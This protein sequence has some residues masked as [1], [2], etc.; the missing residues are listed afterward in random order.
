MGGGGGSNKGDERRCNFL[1]HIGLLGASAYVKLIWALAQPL[2]A[3]PIDQRDGRAISKWL[4]HASRH[5]SLRAGSVSGFLFRPIHRKR[6]TDLRGAQMH[7]RSRFNVR[8]VPLS[9]LTDPVGFE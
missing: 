4:S 9:S 5:T 8:A 3:L 6:Y 2:L 7:P 1:L